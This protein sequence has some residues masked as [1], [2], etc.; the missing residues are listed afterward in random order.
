M[1]MAKREDKQRML[2][3]EQEKI[4]KCPTVNNRLYKRSACLPFIYSLGTTHK[5][6]MAIELVVGSIDVHLWP[7]LVVE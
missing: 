3:G 2:S 5:R 7:G 1:E 4:I 6:P